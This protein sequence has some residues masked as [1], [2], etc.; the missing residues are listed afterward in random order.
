MEKNKLDKFFADKLAQR[1]IEFDPAHWEAAEKLINQQEE[2]GKRRFAWWWL[3]LPLL[4]IGV[5]FSFF[6]KAET[7]SDTDTAKTGI[8]NATIN[9]N[10]KLKNIEQQLPSD[11]PVNTETKNTTATEEL[12]T[13]LQYQTIESKLPNT[14]TQSNT[15]TTSN[16]NTQKTSKTTTTINA[17]SGSETNINQQDA[18]QNP[19]PLDAPSINPN[20]SDPTTKNIKRK[21]NSLPQANNTDYAPAT[22]D[23]SKTPTVSEPD[24]AVVISE[25]PATMEALGLLASLDDIADAEKG[26]PMIIPHSRKK[27]DWGLTAGLQFYK[28]EGQSSFNVDTGTDSTFNN[29]IKVGFTGGLTGAY[30]FS[31]RFS[32]NVDALYHWSRENIDEVGYSDDLEL[33][34]SFGQV[35][36]VSQTK[37]ESFH[38]IQLPVSLQYNIGRHGLEAGLAFRYLLKVQGEESSTASSQRSDGS[39]DLLA[40]ASSKVWVPEDNFNRFTTSYLLGYRFAVNDRLNFGL[41]AMY[42]PSAKSSSDAAETNTAYSV[43]SNNL[44][45]NLGVKYYLNKRSPY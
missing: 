22:L 38:S 8:Y 45:F 5:Y 43:Q 10:T 2:S 17:S 1:Q 42:T 7:N 31:P 24:E 33:L 19:A 32:V 36:Q 23:K 21:G 40:E 3:L 25:S 6:Q 20:S 34:Y 37:A 16:Y 12:N 28:S 11:N 41:R 26:T 4:A 30:R 27:L 35:S 13:T 39:A 44:S 14:T 18:M 9:S 29:S 15:N